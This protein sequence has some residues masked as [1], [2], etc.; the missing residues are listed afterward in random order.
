MRTPFRGPR[1]L[2]LA[3]SVTVLAACGGGQSTA[4]TP[5]SP[6]PT[7]APA[8]A[9]PATAVVTDAPADPT[10]DPTTAGAPSQAAIDEA[11]Q[12]YA[13]R[14]TPC[15]GQDGKGDGMAAAT[16]N[17]K[18]R[19]YRDAAW[20]AITTDESIEKAILE[21]GPAVGLSPLMPPNPD[22]KAK[23]EVVTALRMKVRSF[24]VPAAGTTAPATP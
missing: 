14:C 19:D 8:T 15:H 24:A 3:A 21:G 23:P 10:A 11:A 17:P 2:A 18:P 20:Q 9:A 16:L 12:I 13:M 4:P 1:L 7:A 5:A 22:L 6:A